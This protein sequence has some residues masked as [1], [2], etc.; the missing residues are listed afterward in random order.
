MVDTVSISGKKERLKSQLIAEQKK[1][2]KAES[3]G[4]VKGAKI[5]KIKIAKLTK[6][7]KKPSIGKAA[8]GDPLKIK[9]QKTPAEQ[10]SIFDP[11]KGVFADIWKQKKVKK[12]DYPKVEADDWWGE[13]EDPDWWKAKPES[14]DSLGAIDEDYSGRN[15]PWYGFKHG[16]RI[17]KAKKR[18]PRGVGTALRGYGRAMGHG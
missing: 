14:G 4:D 13:D 16:G 15:D 18:R 5:A 17:K 11:D 8:R 10:A 1:L 2:E 9:K 7:S 6:L 12:E 3:K